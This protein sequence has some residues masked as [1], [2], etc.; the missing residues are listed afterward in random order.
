MSRFCRRRCLAYIY[1][2]NKEY[3]RISEKKEIE[4]KALLNVGEHSL[5]LYYKKAPSGNAGADRA[6]IYNLET[7]TTISDYVAEYD[8][9]N[10]TLT[11]KYITSDDLGS[12]ISE[13][14]IAIVTNERTVQDMCALYSSIIKN[15]V[16][17]LC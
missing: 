15:I 4:I 17:L 7:A 1:L 11:F 14:N 10:T 9:T 5:A 13:H 2:D 16:Q 3:W 8:D 12:L 6:L